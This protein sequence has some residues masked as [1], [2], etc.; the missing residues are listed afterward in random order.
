MQRM[1]T[2]ALLALA[3]P[4]MAQAAGAAA[5]FKLFETVCLAHQTSLADAAAEARS[6][7]FKSTSLDDEALLARGGM[8]QLDG[9]LGS[10]PISV[11]LG[12]DD[13]D[14]LGGKVRNIVCLVRQ[15][16]LLRADLF[17]A[18]RRWVGFEPSERSE[19]Q[20]VYGY[21]QAAKTRTAL[22]SEPAAMRSAIDAGE[23]RQL[24]VFVEEEATVLMI[25]SSA[26]LTT[27]PDP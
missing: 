4:A 2:A 17:F 12:R 8:V 16:R 1:L 3:M 23:Y 11:L 6:R 25:T 27:P 15:D 26:W 14:L 20:D 18:V 10:E 24:S 9:K 22:A 21:R 5:T 7:G 13:F 19:T